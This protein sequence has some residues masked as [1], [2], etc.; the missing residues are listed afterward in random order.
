M[1]LE[2]TSFLLEKYPM[3]VGKQPELKKYRSRENFTRSAKA[4]KQCQGTVA[5]E[6]FQCVQTDQ[7]LARNGKRVYGN[8]FTRRI[9][10]EI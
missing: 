6:H 4:G 9:T 10:R 3:Y 5:N 1:N 2:L 8:L 7:Q